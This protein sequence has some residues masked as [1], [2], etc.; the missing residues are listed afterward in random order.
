[1]IDQ[2]QLGPFDLKVN[3]DDD[4]SLLR[5]IN[6]PP[7]GIS[8]A[9]VSLA[10]DHSIAIGRSLFAALQDPGLVGMLGARAR[11]AVARAGGHPCEGDVRYPYRFLTDRRIR[12]TCE[13]RGRGEQRADG[14]VRFRDP[15]LRPSPARVSLKTLSIDLETTLSADLIFSAAFVCDGVEEV[16]LVESEAKR[17]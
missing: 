7:R 15:E 16:H 8:N 4:V 3:P 2:G 6:N 5:I 12:A 10:T 14:L 9:T 13:I 1:M 11:D 17:S